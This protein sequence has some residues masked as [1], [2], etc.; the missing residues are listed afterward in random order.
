[1]NYEQ[2]EQQAEAYA[3]LKKGEAM[4]LPSLFCARQMAEA[5]RD[6]ALWQRNA[7]WHAAYETPLTG[8]RLLCRNDRKKAKGGYVPD[9]TLL[10]FTKAMADNRLWPFKHV[11]QW[12]YID[13]LLPDTEH[14]ETTKHT[15]R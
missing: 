4:K 12:A 11:M 5:F 9:L 14:T 7:A 2:T 10:T 3:G 15:K 13:D 1:M 8:R 6:G